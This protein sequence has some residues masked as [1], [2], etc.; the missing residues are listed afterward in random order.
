V[1][2]RVG[3]I[4]IA[5]SVRA[6]R[7]CETASPPTWYLPWADV[8]RCAFVA[9]FGSSHCEWKGRASFWSIV[10]G[11]ERLESIAWSYPNAVAPFAALQDCVALYPSR[12]ADCYVDDVLVLGQPGGFYGGWITPELVGP[13]KGGPG[14]SD[15]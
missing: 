13:W 10:A 15:W 14:T 2:V 11:G 9:G 5:R 7:L 6:L 12:G 4:E 3:T 1:V 8:Q